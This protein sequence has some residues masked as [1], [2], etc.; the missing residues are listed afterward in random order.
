[1]LGW[2]EDEQYIYIAMEYY[3]QGNL[4]DFVLQY[5]IQAESWAREVIRQIL[6][7]LAE[8]TASQLAHRNITPSVPL[9]TSS[10]RNN[11]YLHHTRTS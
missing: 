9:S 4:R 7:V 2:Y 8:L 3:E 1:M 5:P 11:N 6:S 10:S